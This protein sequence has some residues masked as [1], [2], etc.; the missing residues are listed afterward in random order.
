MKLRALILTAGIAALTL[1][2]CEPLT[3]P[4]TPSPPPGGPARQITQVCTN[5]PVNN[6]LSLNKVPFLP[7][8]FDPRSNA[9][10]TPNSNVP[11]NADVMSDL[12]AAFVAADHG[13]QTQLCGFDGIFIDPTGCAAPTPTP[14]NPLP[15]YDPHTCN[16]THDQ[17]AD[18]SWGLRTRP[19]NPKPGRRY[20]A[21]SLALWNNQNASDPIN[22]WSCTAPQNTCAP[23]FK[24]YKNALI[25]TV[26]EKLSRNAVNDKFPPKY[27][28]VQPNTGAM[29]VLAVLSHE[30]G[31]VL[32]WD[33][34]VTNP[35]DAQTANTTTF[36]N[37]AFYPANLWTAVD[38]PNPRW[39][40]F[41]QLRNLPSGSPILKVQNGL[42]QGSQ[43]NQK[44]FRDA[45]DDLDTI[46]ASNHWVSAL[47][48][49]S[50]DEQFVT[51][52]ELQV[53]HN[54]GLR[55]AEIIITGNHGPHNHD[56]APLPCF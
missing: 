46:Y 5:D 34:F 40:S 38:V 16:L 9:T 54:A 24:V 50:P 47:A 56:P 43:Q 52:F 18:S 32:W 39:I 49:F 29:T 13:F 28:N 45:G 26:L 20:I 11:M 36:C 51:A 1:F 22:Q 53:L 3:P 30:F 55:H 14:T 23:P 31:H 42:R 17:I 27:G 37:G 19:P 2:S 10:P 33:T 12:S 35:N 15:S 6:L 21:L 4:T 7:T 48:A 44:G 8:G 41:G 25:R